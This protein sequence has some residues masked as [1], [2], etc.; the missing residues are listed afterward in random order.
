MLRNAIIQA[1]FRDL[2]ESAERS[3]ALRLA[4][5]TAPP[6]PLTSLDELVSLGRSGNGSPWVVPHESLRRGDLVEL[7]VQ[8]EAEPIYQADAVMSG[9][10][11][12][13]QD[14]PAEIGRAHV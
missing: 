9:L 12:I 6:P 8:L 13:I 4:A 1:A 2:R 14:D 7:D 10:L 11:E 5:T 3:G